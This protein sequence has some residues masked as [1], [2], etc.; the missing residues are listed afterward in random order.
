DQERGLDL[1]ALI[2]LAQ[3][4]SPNLALAES[5]VASATGREQ[6]AA[7]R[8][9]PEINVE[10]REQ[11]GGTDVATSVGASWM[12]DNGRL[13]PRQAIATAD[14]QAAEWDRADARRVLAAGIRAA[15]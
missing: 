11:I 5:I 13:R 14:R 4:H 10:R 9:N 12:L 2:A 6:Q 3:E 7:L 8:S 1:R 15:Y